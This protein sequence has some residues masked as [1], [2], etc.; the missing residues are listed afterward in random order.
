MLLTFKDMR[1]KH[2]KKC[3]LKQITRV[4][5]VYETLIGQVSF[6]PIIQFPVF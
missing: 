6:V 1:I 4:I 2:S 5:S 3:R